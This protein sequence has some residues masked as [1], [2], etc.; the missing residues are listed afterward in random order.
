MPLS[1]RCHAEQ[2]DPVAELAGGTDIGLA[3]IADA[4]HVDLFR[5]DAG[6]E[7]EAGEDGELVGGVVALDVEG[8]IGFRIAEALGVLETGVE[9][10]PLGLHARQDIVAGAVQ[11]AEYARHLVAGHRFTHRLDDRDAAGHRRLVVEQHALGLR[12]RC[13]RHPMARQK[14]FVGGNDVV[15]GLQRRGDAVECGAVRPADQFDEDVDIG[16]AGQ[17][18]GVVVPARR[19]KRQSALAQPVTGADAGQNQLPAALAA[20]LGLPFAE[21]SDNR[22]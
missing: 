2:L 8:R 12:R 17:R 9:A 16:R 15:A 1:V 13:K 10:Q 21:H 22:R 20:Q 5:G 3:D 18:D 7:G 6:A 4:F 14:R 19:A 11:N